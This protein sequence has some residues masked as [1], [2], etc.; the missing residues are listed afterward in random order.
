M[1]FHLQHELLPS[2]YYAG[3][4]FFKSNSL[5]TLFLQEKEKMERKGQA[6][7]ATLLFALTHSLTTLLPTTNITS[8][9]FSNHNALCYI[10][11]WP[12]SNKV[13]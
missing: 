4:Q 10:V 13:I 12:L 1:P 2:V 5:Q 6:E 9:G 11:A 8:N 3:L 7:D